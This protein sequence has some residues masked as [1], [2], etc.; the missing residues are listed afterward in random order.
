MNNPLN[1]LDT[2]ELLDKIE[3]FKKIDMKNT[4]M[5]EIS[6]RSLE[7]LSCMIVRSC[8]F[9]EGSR[10]YRVRKLKADLSNMP[11]QFQDIW[12]P[13]AEY[14]TKDGR[15]NLK[16]QPMLYC[17]TEQIT[18]L[19]E[20]GIEENDFYA[21]IQYSICAGKSL[22][23]YTVGSDSEPE[24]LNEV[25]KLN[26]K[27]INDFVVSEFTKPVGIG[28]EY[29]Y[30]VSNVIAQNFMDMPFCDAYVYPSIA[31]YKKGWNVAVKPESAKEKM[32]FD[33]VLI[34]KS[35]GVDA[36]NNMLFE[37]L[38]KANNIIDNSLVYV[39]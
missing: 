27:I 39:F 1:N 14:V 17:S 33:C 2:M 18:P 20:C 15:V 30:K 12:H 6:M 34:C 9:A 11:R 8:S 37:V 36:E 28:T 29:L 21:L 3:T 16:G 10:L 38:H 26:N 19:Y 23:G 25:G 35:R 32:K 13:K 7:T 24:G 5:Q 31:N 22:I 4:S